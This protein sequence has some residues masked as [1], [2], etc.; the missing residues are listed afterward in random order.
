MQVVQVAIPVPMYQVFDY[1]IE[2]EDVGDIIA[3]RVLVPFGPRKV[4]GIVMGHAEHAIVEEKKLKSVIE[5]LDS[6]PVCSASMR[7]LGEWMSR[8]YHYPIGEVLHTLLPAALRKQASGKTKASVQTETMLYLSDEAKN[9]DDVDPRLS[10]SQKQRA[11]FHFILASAEQ[12]A[13][14]SKVKDEFSASVVKAMIEK[15]LLIKREEELQVGDWKQSIQIADKPLANVDQSIAISSVN[16]SNGFDTFLIEGVTGSGKTEVYLQII[17]PLLLEGKQILI[18]VPEI[19][20]TPQTVQR[21]EDRFGIPVGMLHSNLNDTER[22]TVWQ[23]ARDGN[24]GI[25]IGTRSSIFTELKNPGMIIV[26]EEHDES[27]KQ[28]DNLKYH[29]RDIAV[30]RAKQLNIPLVLGS[31]TPSLESLHNAIEKKYKHLVLPNRAGSA[32]MPSQR[33]MNIKGQQMQFGIAQG[34]LD[35]MR[36]Q[37]QA[38]N[39]VMVFVN[40]RG[41]APALLCHQCGHVESC[42]RCDNPMTVHKSVNNL[43]CHRCA[44]TRYLPKRCPECGS[45]DVDT[46]GV[47]T[48]QMQAGLEEIFAEYDTVRID[49]DTVRGKGKLNRLLQDINQKKYQVLVGTQILSKG[50][51]FPDVT[52]V[53]I[54]DV[55][56]A[57]FSADFRA[58]EKLA[59]LI[60]QLSGRAGRSGKAGE[61]WLQT[62]CPEHPLL[63]DL[64]NNGYSDFARYALL[65]R[66]H[67][68]LPP[69]EHQICIRSESHKKGLAMDFLKICADTFTQFQHAKVLG[70]FPAFIE[71]RQGR[72]RFVLIVQSPS[73]NYLQKITEQANFGLQTLAI[74]RQVRWSIDVSP[75]DF[76]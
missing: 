67:A 76:S 65:E 75:I 59:Q 16:V 4:V 61:M 28:Q 14:L 6:T 74:S 41:Y 39:Q 44:D 68:G 49:S 57:L 10:R 56:S 60:T 13:P 24:I 64:I 70:P 20:L 48:E 42:Q 34:M 30:Y 47:G 46:F 36:E 2:S 9:I 54:V 58:P 3:C 69:Y 40:R 7:E 37:L 38:G 51:H 29:A 35:K 18:L 53:L 43:Q 52:L 23:Q 19:G 27:F 15:D 73:R 5:V 66:K 32:S 55:D 12:K 8:Y 17:E 50:H 11:L 31:A 26:D 22:L 45:D 21:F 63:Q 72:F 25:V 62:H 1:R 71:K 33:L